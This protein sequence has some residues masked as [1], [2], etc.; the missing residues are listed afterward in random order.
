MYFLE[1][2]LSP[3]CL[4]NIQLAE[5]ENGVELLKLK[6]SPHLCMH[7][8]FYF[9]AV[10]GESAPPLLPAM[11][12]TLNESKDIVF[13]DEFYSDDSFDSSSSSNDD[14]CVIV[15]SSSS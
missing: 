2:Y 8:K 12:A 6:A 13:F 3:Y 11:S 9:T 7:N 15:T 1:V 10:T 5:M 14:E 4:E